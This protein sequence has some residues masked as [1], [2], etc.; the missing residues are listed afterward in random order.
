MSQS[1]YTR[2]RLAEVAES[3]R[4]LTEAMVTLGVDPRSRSRRYLR[5]RMKSM[6][7][8]TSHFEREGTRWTRE[9][10]REAVAASTN[11]NE[12]LRRL[13]V[14]TVGGQHTHISRRV[15]TLGL[16]T[17]HFTGAPATA[18]PR[19]HRLPEEILVQQKA[20]GG[21]RVPSSRL[22]QLMLGAGVEDRCALCGTP[23]VWRDRPLPL[24]VDHIDGSWRNNR[25]E[26]LRLLCP[27]CHSVTDTYRGRNKRK[28]LSRE[29]H[30]RPAGAS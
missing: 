30:G 11:M 10:L 4:S 5:E 6:G 19:R 21:R 17:S 7:I 28:S 12:V 25:L 29:A 23:P 26:N 24:E 9:V 8:D 27:S 2:A 1:P 15:R 13:G 3:S 20:E 14:E 16:D 18:G 22:K